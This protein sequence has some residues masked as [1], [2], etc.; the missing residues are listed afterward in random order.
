M[1]ELINR[2]ANQQLDMA[3]DLVEL[4]CWLLLLLSCSIRGAVPILRSAVANETALNLLSSTHIMF[5]WLISHQPTALFSQNKPTIQQYFSFTT[6]QHQPNEQ[7]VTQATSV[8]VTWLGRPTGPGPG[9]PFTGA[10]PPPGFS[11]INGGVVSV[12]PNARGV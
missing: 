6:N 12:L 2:A 1:L 3:A 10:T 7:A 5:A 4:C 11:S 9:L 8:S